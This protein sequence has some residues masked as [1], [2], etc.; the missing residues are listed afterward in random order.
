LTELIDKKCFE[1]FGKTE[2]IGHDIQP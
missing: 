2:H 1:G